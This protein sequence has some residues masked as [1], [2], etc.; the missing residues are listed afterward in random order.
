MSLFKV[1][2]LTLLYFDFPNAASYS[3]SVLASYSAGVRLCQPIQFPVGDLPH[4]HV[5]FS[6]L[7][8]IIIFFLLSLKIIM[9][10]GDVRNN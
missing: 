3:L 5:P 8:F 1:S 2:S 10:T 4:P 6:F 7:T 9:V